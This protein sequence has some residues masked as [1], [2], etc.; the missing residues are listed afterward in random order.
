MIELRY[1][2]RLSEGFCRPLGRNVIKGGVYRIEDAELARRL[3]DSN[4]FRASG[5]ICEWHSPEG[6][7]CSGEAQEGGL[8]TRHA[9]RDLYG[10]APGSKNEVLI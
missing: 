7:G 8:C 1:V 5:P 9:T 4:D 2:G 6:R 3:I 10:I